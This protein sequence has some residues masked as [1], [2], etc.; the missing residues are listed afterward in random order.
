MENFENTCFVIMPFSSPPGYDSDHFTKVY[1]QIFKPAIEKAGYKAH[2]ADEDKLSTSIVEKIF[3]AVSEC[4]IA[5]CDLS[6]GNPNV[7]YELG[8][9]NAYDLP[10][11]LVKDDKTKFI[12]DVSGISTIQ[13]DSH[14]LYENVETAKKNIT[15]ALTEYKKK[16]ENNEE[17]PT[18]AKIVRVTAAQQLGTISSDGTN[19]TNLMF[20]M[21]MDEVNN[22]KRTLSNN[23]MPTND[24]FNLPDN[25]VEYLFSIRENTSDS[26]IGEYIE[27][28]KF[29][30]PMV[31]FEIMFEIG[32]TST[33]KKVWIT[34]KK[35]DHRHLKKILIDAAKDGILI[36][37]QRI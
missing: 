29:R 35:S 9:R 16:S 24:D 31:R 13:Y 2:R 12:F 17:I 15:E 1:E 5:L 34:A 18:V 27:K 33:E 26:E 10:V 19:N 14:R 7:L 20:Q 37:P 6:S 11:V 22:I 28:L 4:P 8:L 3:K 32:D 36:N 21:I 23:G 30:Y 25:I